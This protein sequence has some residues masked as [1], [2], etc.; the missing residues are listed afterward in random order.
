MIFPKNFTNL[1]G[2]SS[3]GSI[4]DAIGE[5]SEIFD[6]VLENGMNSC[7]LSEH[8]NMASYVSAYLYQ[9]KLKQ[10]GINFKYLPACEFYFYPDLN[11][12]KRD[13]V[14][15]E[16]NKLNAKKEKKEKQD[17]EITATVEN[18]EET[19]S[20]KY[21]NPLKRRHHL[22]VLAKTSRG[23]KNLFTL[24]S[25][26]YKNGFYYFPRIDFNWLKEYGEDLIVS[27]ACL[28]TIFGHP[29]F[30]RFQNLSI[31]ELIPDL[32]EKDLSTKSQILNDAENLVDRFVDAVGKENFFLEIQFNKIPAQHLLNK[33]LIETSKK[34]GINLV[35]IAKYFTI[36]II[37]EIFGNLANY[38]RNL[39]GLI[40]KILNLGNFLN[41]LMN[42]RRNFIQKTPNKCGPHI[43]KQQKIM[44]FIMTKLFAMLLRERIVLLT[45]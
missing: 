29:I 19:K 41:L 5:S 28:G 18:E 24:V 27:S 14:K 21:F 23:L 8:A 34:T 35:A 11:E 43:N 42:L 26:G 1:H 30:S 15:H 33:V 36:I 6:F 22:V 32:L 10:K 44:I 31:D 17:D 37:R 25:K 4:L 2:H 39:V 45:I 13:L 40:I 9:K 3:Q 16:E 7:A 20:G 38:I 12:W